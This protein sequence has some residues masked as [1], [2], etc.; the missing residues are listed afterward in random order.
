MPKAL[1]AAREV[2]L[3]ESSIYILEGQAEGR[4]SVRDIV[5][6]VKKNNVKR[7]PVKPAKKDT[8]AYM[9][10]SSGTTGLPK[11]ASVCPYGPIFS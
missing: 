6:E 11:G 4:R 7:L 2:G 3:P 10:F 8:L 1:L 5:N 9:I